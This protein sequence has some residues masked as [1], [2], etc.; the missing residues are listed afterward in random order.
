MAERGGQISAAVDRGRLCMSRDDV[1]LI[2]AYLFSLP[3]QH[4][5]NKENNLSFLFN[6]PIGGRS[7]RR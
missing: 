6:Q 1:L 2:R 7:R 5:A 4:V 3:P